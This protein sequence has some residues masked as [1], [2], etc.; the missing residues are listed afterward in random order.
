MNVHRFEKVWIAASMVLIVAWI[1]TVTWGAVG[2]PGIAMIDDSGGTVD[3]GAIA[4][5]QYDG[6]FREPGVYRVGEDHYAVYVVA[7]QF[8]FDPGSSAPI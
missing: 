1:A 2:P 5:N 8:A 4:N 7:R 3:Q 6:A